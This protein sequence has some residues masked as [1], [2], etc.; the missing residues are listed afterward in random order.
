VLFQVM[1]E[2]L[3]LKAFDWDFISKDDPLGDASIDLSVL[4]QE[5]SH[6]LKVPLSTQVNI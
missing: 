4:A 3:E 1:R 5:K 6:T 2:R